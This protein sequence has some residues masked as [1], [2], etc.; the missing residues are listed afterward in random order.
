MVV[1]LY[2]QLDLM[3]LKVFSSHNKFYDSMNSLSHH[4]EEKLLELMSLRTMLRRKVTNW[5]FKYCS[6]MSSL[7]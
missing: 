2:R 4:F 3:I 5:S 6:I 1:M 7:I